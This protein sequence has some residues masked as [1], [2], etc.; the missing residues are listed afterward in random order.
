MKK[1]NEFYKREST[2]LRDINRT[3]EFIEECEVEI[4]KIQNRMKRNQRMLQIY[5]I[6]LEEFKKFKMENENAL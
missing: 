5:Q 2:Y 6:E 1:E 4:L 3:K